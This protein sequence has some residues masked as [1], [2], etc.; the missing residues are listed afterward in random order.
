MVKDKD[1]LKKYTLETA[2]DMVVCVNSP[3]KR[4][5]WYV[6]N[7]EFKFS[8]DK[9]KMKNKKHKNKNKN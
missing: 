8:R 6:S 5:V 4:L 1:F 3:R 7:F 2:K 9:N